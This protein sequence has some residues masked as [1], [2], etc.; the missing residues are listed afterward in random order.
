MPPDSSRASPETDR[1]TAL[2]ELVVSGC[3]AAPAAHN[4]PMA[5]DDPDVAWFVE[6]GAV[7]IFVVECRNGV[8]ESSFT[9]VAHAEAGRLIFGFAGG[10]GAGLTTILRGLPASML[11]RV[12]LRTLCGGPGEGR[13]AGASDPNRPPPPDADAVAAEVVR[14]V[15]LWVEEVAAV[16]AG[17][18]E[19]RPAAVARLVPGTSRPAAAR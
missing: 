1:G 7:D 3:E 14:Q 16:V 17:H 18:I 6:R 11:R 9:H 4:L 2:R 10:A 8:V 5:L 12:P 15:D 13:A 19:L